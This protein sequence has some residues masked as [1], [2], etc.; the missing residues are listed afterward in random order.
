MNSCN[1]SLAGPSFPHWS[2]VQASHN[3]SLDLV[4]LILKDDGVVGVNLER[5]LVVLGGLHELTLS[6]DY[7]AE[8]ALSVSIVGIYLKCSL[9][10]FGGLHELPLTIKEVSVLRVGR[11]VAQVKQKKLIVTP[12]CFCATT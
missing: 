3:E 1:F 6:L 4:R 7:V 10:V 11:G 2:P 12:R 8:V 5:G 9:V